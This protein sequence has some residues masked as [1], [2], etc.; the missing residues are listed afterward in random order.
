MTF[1]LTLLI[2]ALVIVG[3]SIGVLMGRTPIKGSC[4][5]M[6]NIGMK[7]ACD[8]CGGDQQRCDKER[9]RRSSDGTEP[10]TQRLAYD[11]ARDQRTESI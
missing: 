1:I 11:A 10:K 7:T 5:G 3:M 6:S 9:E 2:L 4:G 8:I